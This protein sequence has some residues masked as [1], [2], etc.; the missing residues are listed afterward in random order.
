MQLTFLRLLMVRPA[1]ES[2]TLVHCD[3]VS[4]ADGWVESRTN[5]LCAVSVY[6]PHRYDWR[7]ACSFSC[8]EDNTH[9]HTHT[10]THTAEVLSDSNVFY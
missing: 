5:E 10:H 2:H 1:E 3:P 6:I 8:S 7:L 4:H 9:T